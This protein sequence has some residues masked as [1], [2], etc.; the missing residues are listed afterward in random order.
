MTN[1]PEPPFYDDPAMLREALVQL[2]DAREAGKLGVNRKRTRSLTIEARRRVLAKTNHRCHVC[3]IEIPE[4]AYFEADHV[5]NHTSGGSS[6]EA[7]FLASCATCN[8]ARWH[9]SPQELQWILKLGVYAV[10]E[11]RK[12]TVV[13]RMVGD[14]FISKEVQ[15][16]NRRKNPRK[17]SG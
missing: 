5:M 9:Y 4:G 6:D 8:N 1:V 12:G 14:H 15:R 3:G 7:N 16:E 2:C 13:G 10:N 11:I 17:P